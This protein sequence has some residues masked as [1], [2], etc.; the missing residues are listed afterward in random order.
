MVNLLHKFYLSNFIKYRCAS[1]LFVINWRQ[2]KSEAFCLIQIS[3]YLTAVTL[4]VTEGKWTPE[5]AFD[6][7]TLLAE[8]CVEGGV[9]G[10]RIA[11]PLHGFNVFL[12][13]T[14]GEK[15]DVIYGH[16]T[17]KRIKSSYKMNA[18]KTR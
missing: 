2:L 15:N 17:T 14:C 16:Y 7:F 5:G 13:V 3:T 18:F 10:Y 9:P 11:Q 12:A 1:W 8:H 4:R 6:Q